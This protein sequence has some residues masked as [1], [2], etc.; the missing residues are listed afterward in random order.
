MSLVG[1]YMGA[2][3]PDTAEPS[4]GARLLAAIASAIARGI[5][6]DAVIENPSGPSSGI[7]TNRP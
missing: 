7:N 1:R 6:P 4:Y 2:G 5:V 3:D